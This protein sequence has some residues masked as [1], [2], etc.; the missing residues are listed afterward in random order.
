[1]LYSS[2]MCMN[3]PQWTTYLQTDNK[4]G[5]RD[6]DYVIGFKHQALSIREK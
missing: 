1:M 6:I 3:K 2:S 5:E 4:I